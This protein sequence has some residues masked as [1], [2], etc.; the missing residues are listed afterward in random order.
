VRIWR[1]CVSKMQL[2]NAARVVDL[3]DPVGPVHRTRPRCFSVRSMNGCGKP[4]SCHF[5]RLSGR[6]LR[7]KQRFSFAL[8]ALILI[9]DR[10][11]SPIDVSKSPVR[12][13]CSS[14][15]SLISSDKRRFMS[16]GLRIFSRIR[17][18]E[19]T[20]MAIGEPSSR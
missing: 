5:G 7:V 14:L 9:R 4:R 1:F 13:Y 18:S 20:R 19:F 11:S 16:I 3:P 12:L 6:I 15:S 8:Y 17:I 10:P 2:I